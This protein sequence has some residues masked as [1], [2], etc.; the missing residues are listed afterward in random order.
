MGWWKSSGPETG[1]IACSLPSGHPGEK[2]DVPVNAISGRDTPDD[3]YMGDGPADIMD[4]AISSIV[5]EYQA[6]WKRPPHP[7]E[8]RACFSFCFNAW[9]KQTETPATS[10]T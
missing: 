10:A 6:Q 1:G 7:D 3:D 9:K 2:T 5:A 4:R 8:L